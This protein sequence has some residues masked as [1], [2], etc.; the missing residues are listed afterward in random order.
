MECLGVTEIL[1]S[2][3]IHYIDML[4]RVEPA[5]ELSELRQNGIS[6]WPG[7][8]TCVRCNNWDISNG[9]E[10]I[11]CVRKKWE[12]T[13]GD[14]LKHHCKCFMNILISLG[15]L[16]QIVCKSSLFKLNY[17]CSFRLC[18]FVCVGEGMCM[19]HVEVRGQLSGVNSLC[20]TCGFQGWNSGHQTTRLP[21]VYGFFLWN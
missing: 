9:R 13:Q 6:E 15:R 12:Q 19:S 4:E 21:P 20:L 7:H 11:I 16:C 10:D 1:L 17:L 18:M 8:K 3:M 2:I 5:S 14:W